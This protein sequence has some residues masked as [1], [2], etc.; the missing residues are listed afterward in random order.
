MLDERSGVAFKQLGNSVNVSVVARI[1]RGFE[2]LVI[3]EEV[4]GYPM[5]VGF[6]RSNA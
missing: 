2:K 1:L 5:V 4:E 6:Q 3:E